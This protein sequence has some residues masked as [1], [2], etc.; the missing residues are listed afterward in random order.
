MQHRAR[1]GGGPLQDVA[2]RLQGVCSPPPRRP[3][4]LERQWHPVLSTPA[5][6]IVAAGTHLPACAWTCCSGSVRAH[7]LVHVT[8]GGGVVQ[9]LLYRGRK[10]GGLTDQ[11]LEFARSEEEGRRFGAEPH[12]GVEAVQATA[13]VG[14][15][16]RRGT[17]TRQVLE[18][19]TGVRS[20]VHEAR[21]RHGGEESHRRSHKRHAA[22]G[23]VRLL[24]MPGR[25][26]QTL[27]IRFRL[28]AMAK[29]A[30]SQRRPIVLVR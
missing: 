13:L 11:K 28:Q 25:R 29:N 12:F 17:F 7:H 5:Q 30:G 2:P 3:P 23:T 9:G 4:P 15:A 27:H 16:A 26:D 14:A 24:A 1:S 21:V 18:A 10:E 8:R 6:V 19:I 22:W 20:T